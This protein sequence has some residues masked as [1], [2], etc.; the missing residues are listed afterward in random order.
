MLTGINGRLLW[1]TKLDSMETRAHL[2]QALAVVRRHGGKALL[3]LVALVAA[4]LAG[5]RLIAGPR[6][7]VATVVQRDFIQTVVA[8]GRIETPHRVDIAAQVTGTVL[9]VPVA[10]GQTVAAGATLI[11]LESSE[12]RAALH[13][14][15]FA[16]QQAQAR[17]RQLREVQEPV[18]E[19]ALRQAQANYD[20]T[21]LVLTRNRNLFDKGFIGQAALDEAQRA[22]L[23]A[24]AQLRSAQQQL[25]SA[26]PSGPDTALAQT[27]LAQAQAAADMARARLRY[28]TISAPVAGTLIKRDVESGDVVQPGKILLVLSPAGET[29]LV[30]QIEERNLH[31][32]HLGA[33]ALGSAD[34]YQQQRFAAELVYI[35]PGIDA[36]RGA[37]EV[38]LRVPE[39]PSYLRQD[40]TVSVDIEVAR[41]SDAVLVPADALR[42]ADSPAPWVLKVIDGHA[43]RQA[44]KIGLR[45]GGMCEVLDGLQPGEEVVPVG[46][47]QVIDGA[48]IR[49]LAKAAVW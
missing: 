11:E 3:L 6:I 20:S 12:L 47:A 48:R 15:E 34:A 29:Q 43:R 22:Q 33:P 13:Q 17:L 39:P 45:S 21:Q 5:P 40:M 49:P 23:V 1:S 2:S 4:V 26:R 7:P 28:A 46:L 18:A 27:A 8:S 44:V 19:Q 38:K 10:E 31:L 36:Q 25:S 42:E 9:R 32:L 24:Q 16:V 41:R 14:A 30:V 37:V 35:N